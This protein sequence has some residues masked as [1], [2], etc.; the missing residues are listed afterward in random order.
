MLLH[1]TDPDRSAERKQS[2]VIVVVDPCRCFAA[3]TMINP[4]LLLL[5]PL[6]LLLIDPLLLLLLLLLKGLI[7]NVVA[8]C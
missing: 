8:C 6:V 4:L 2:L 7:R 5:L 3:A 1:A